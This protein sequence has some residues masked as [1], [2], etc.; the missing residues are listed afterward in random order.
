MNERSIAI[1]NSPGSVAGLTAPQAERSAALSSSRPCSGDGRGAH[2]RR[3]FE[4][5]A[6]DEPAN[7]F[8]DQVE[9]GWIDQVALGQG[10][11]A[12]G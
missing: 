3:A 7:L 12:G 11:D 1:R 4:K 9:P 2:D 10:D 6:A 8:F 5:R